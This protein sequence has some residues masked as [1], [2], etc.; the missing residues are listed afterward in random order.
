ML[1]VVVVVFYGGTDGGN[2]PI[3]NDSLR[4]DFGK[5]EGVGGGGGGVTSVVAAEGAPASAVA[6]EDRQ[7]RAAPDGG[8]MT[9]FPPVVRLEI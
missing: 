1:V 4:R 7:V 9:P 8:N 2:A 6:P 5:G 3:V